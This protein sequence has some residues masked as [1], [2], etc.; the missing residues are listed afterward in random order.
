MTPQELKLYISMYVPYC[1]E[2]CL[3]KDHSIRD[4][5]RYEHVE[6]VVA[7]E[8]LLVLKPNP[9]GTSFDGLDI[10]FRQIIRLMT[11]HLDIFNLIPAGYAIEK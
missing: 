6:S 3:A 8:W 4:N 1:S 11:G 2:I 5:F 10:N 7:K 9:Y